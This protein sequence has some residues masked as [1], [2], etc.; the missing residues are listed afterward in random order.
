MMLATKKDYRDFILSKKRTKQFGSIVR[1]EIPVSLFDYQ[2]AIL[3]WALKKGRCA[4]FAGTGLGKSYM[5]L[6][7]GANVARETGKPV[8][9]MC[10]LAVADQIVA[11]AKRFGIC[12]ER[13]DYQ[14]D[15]QHPI[16][17]VTNYA[18]L[19]RFNPSQFGGIILDESSIIKH[20]DGKTKAALIE[21][22]REISFRLASTA[23]PAPNDYMELG[24]HA[25][26]LGVCSSAEMLA[27][28]FVHDGGE[29]SKW[30]LKGH[31]QKPFWQWVCSWS[32]L[33]RSPEDLGFDGSSHVLPE[34][35]EEQITVNS[36]STMTGFMFP[37]EAQTLQERLGARRETIAERVEAAAN[38]VNAEPNEH[39]VCWCHLNKESEA[40]AESIPGSVELRGDQSDDQKER[41]LRDFSQGKI[42]VLVCKPGMAG[43]GLN[44]QHCARMIFVGLNDSWEQV[45]Q[46]IRRCWRFGQKRPVKVYYVAADIEGDVVRN[47]KR[48][49][50]QAKEM[51]NSMA[52]EVSVFQSDEVLNSREIQVA[53][54]TATNKTDLYEVRLG[55]CV[56]E[57]AQMENESID[58]SIYSP[59]FSSLYTYSAS[60]RDMGNTVSDDEFF[61]HYRFLVREIFRITKPGRLTAFHCML[62]PSTKAFHGEIGLRDFRG[63]LIRIHMEEGWIYH[64]EHCIWK[65]PVVAMQRTKALGLL[66]KTIKKD[67]SMSRAGI[68]DYLVSC[69]KPGKNPE[70]ISHTAEQFP[71]KEWQKIASPIWMDINQSDT[72]Q[73]KSAREDDDERHICP[74]QLEV[75][76]RALKL[77]SN[78]GDLVL[79]PFAGIGSEGFV[80]I[81]QGRRF[82]GVELKKSY[83]EQAC[84]NLAKASDKKTEPLLFDFDGGEK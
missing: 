17:Y 26:F 8:I 31:A 42:R 52:E 34:L 18:K 57:T 69:R 4:I 32:V 56:E 27:T 16:V 74:L 58:F 44:W 71:V 55:D 38:V 43:F 66:W 48:K 79:S 72:L 60:P 12:A 84:A 30:R 59:P 13:A 11:E 41:I 37:L 3:K 47:L 51:A 54:A 83:Y 82:V 62:L 70:P 45:Y 75:I 2:K 77:Y 9:L 65:D 68:A 78:P 50:Q 19:Q 20:Q 63:E 1:S 73:H 24:S 22:T 61:E 7:W 29:T 15:V 21:F 67:S 10:P 33:L 46:A 80:S 14:D 28:F 39:W 5:E 53:Y 76:R 49:D 35:I 23:T 6:A 36:E 25:E 81:E 40:L 64:S